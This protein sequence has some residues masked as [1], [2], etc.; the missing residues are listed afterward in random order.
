MLNM[1][2]IAAM[3]GCSVLNFKNTCFTVNV[4]KYI[5]RYFLRLF[6]KKKCLALKKDSLS[7]VFRTV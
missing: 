6:D 2:R 5:L 4:S 3:L 7:I 1:L